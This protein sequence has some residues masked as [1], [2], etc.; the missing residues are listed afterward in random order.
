MAHPSGNPKSTWRRAFW[1]LTCLWVALLPGLAF[2][3]DP[4]Y[5]FAVVPQFERR[6]VF[7]IWKPIVDELQRRSGVHLDLVT[8]MSVREYGAAMQAGQYDFVYTNPYYIVKF[9]HLQPYAP[10]VRDSTPI[11]GIIV[12]PVNSP[13]QKPE[14]LQ[15]KTLAVPT[16]NAFGASLMTQADLADLYHVT[17]RPIDGKTHTSAYYHALNGLTDAAGGVQKTLQE[18]DPA[19]RD[20]L[21]VV[22]TTRDLPSHPV[23]A[24]TRVPAK[25][26][27]AIRTAWLAM[28][29]DPAIAPLLAKVPMQHSIATSIDDYLPVEK[30]GLDRYWV[31]Q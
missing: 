27:G 31:D 26:Q 12:V 4:T 29:A 23:A 13:I 1:L 8:T 11:R 14:D 17:V 18:Q 16:F 28:A 10:L 6:K 3:A 25:V 5:S 21:R 9:R 30:L 15:G 24:H 19:V 22:Y 20:S 2:A 7:A